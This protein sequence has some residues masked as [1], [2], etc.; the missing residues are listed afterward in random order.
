MK[1]EI[2]L[3]ISSKDY[4]ITIEDDEFARVL[5][6]DF[7]GFVGG[8]K[9]LTPK[10]LLDAYVQKCYDNYINECHIKEVLENV[11]KNLK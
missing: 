4:I 3:T 8:R 2:T 10:E 1:N 6:R 9:F 5:E 11:E 7:G